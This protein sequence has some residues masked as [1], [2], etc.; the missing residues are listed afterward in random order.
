MAD[1]GICKDAYR[2]SPSL[3]LPF[4]AISLF[5]GSPAIRSSALTESLAQAA[6]DVDGVDKT[7]VSPMSDFQ[8]RL[9]A[10]RLVKNY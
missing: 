4:F 8:F 1:R 3:F 6:F 10:Y 9:S 7:C 2:V 5:H